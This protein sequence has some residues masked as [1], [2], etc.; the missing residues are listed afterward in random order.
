MCLVIVNLN[1]VFI[2][3]VS[4]FFIPVTAL[5]NAPST[6][7]NLSLTEASPSSE[8]PI[9]L[10]LAFLAKIAFSSV[11]KVPFVD[12]TGLNPSESAY[13]TSSN[14]S[15]R[16]RGSPPENSTTGHPYLAISSKKSLPSSVDSSP[17]SGRAVAAA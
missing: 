12:I 10:T 3:A 17:S 5:L 13:S 8:T 16:S 11:I 1:P 2:P 9:Y 4:E 15:L 6:P 7:L 14:R